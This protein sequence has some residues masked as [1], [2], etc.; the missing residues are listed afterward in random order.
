MAI[1]LASGFA[2]GMPGRFAAIAFVPALVRGF[3]WFAGARRPLDVH[4]LGRSELRHA[5][6]FG[7]LLVAGLVY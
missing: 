5:I 4:A 1:A 6:L 2:A 3:A 7:G